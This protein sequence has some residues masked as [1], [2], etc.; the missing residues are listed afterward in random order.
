MKQNTTESVTD[1][2]RHV[3]SNAPALYDEYWYGN[4]HTIPSTTSHQSQW[5]VAK[6]TGSLAGNVYSTRTVT[7][8]K[9]YRY[10]GHNCDPGHLIGT[11]PLEGGSGR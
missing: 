3:M 7:S 10:D 2:L 4:Y 8:A 11:R 9:V 6:V 1:I 5:M